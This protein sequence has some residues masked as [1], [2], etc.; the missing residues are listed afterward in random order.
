MRVIQDGPA[1]FAWHGGPGEEAERRQQPNLD[2]KLE[3]Q[4]ATVQMLP[5]IK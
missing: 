1:S 2:V 5:T 4:A 3:V